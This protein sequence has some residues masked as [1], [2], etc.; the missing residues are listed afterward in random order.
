MKEK[1][2]TF[3]RSTE[4]YT[5]TNT[6]HLVVNN[7]WLNFNRGLGILN[8]L[9]L[10][11]AFAH[12]IT[13]EA[14]GTYAFVLAVIGL[15]GMPTTT[16]LGAGSAKAVSRGSYAVIFDS[17]RIIFPWSIA[18]GLGL[19]LVGL[20]YLIAGNS[21]LGYSF[22]LGAIILPVSFANSAAKSFLNSKGDFQMIATFNLWRT[23]VMSAVLI[24]TAWLSESA[25]YIIIANLVGNLIL[26]FLLYLG[27]KKTY[28]KEL[29]QKT[30]EVFAR[31]F[32]FHSA[33][34]SI[35]SYLSEKVDSI[36][37]WKFAGAAPVAIYNYALSPVKELR[38]LIETQG[39]IAAPKF[40]QKEFSEVRKGLL[41]RIGQLYVVVVILLS[42]YFFLSP[43]LFKYLFPQYIEAVGLSKILALSL[44]TIPRKIIATAI[45]AHQKIKES[46]LTNILPNV[47]RIILVAV[48]VPSHGI[49]GAAIAFLVAEIIDYIVLVILI[50]FPRELSQ[51]K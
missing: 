8:G 34:I 3:F 21:V 18:S 47:V 30:N 16:A 31:G 20:Y 38:N 6:L 22:I 41:L 29:T 9:A 33:I 1:I 51:A 4:K 2:K 24:F 36:L 15:F 7:F 50:K 25:L 48:L 44:L 35:F 10:S 40:A 42:I 26:G 46:Y 27:V 12:F 14:Y 5:R 45:T 28:G 11:V 49:N 37:L 32:A 19:G 17:I 23:P 13:K 39:V 43:F